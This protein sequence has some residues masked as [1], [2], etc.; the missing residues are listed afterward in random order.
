[1]TQKKTTLG[2]G[3]ANPAKRYVIAAVA[4]SLPYGAV[5]ADLPVP[6]P[7]SDVTVTDP[8]TQYFL[9]WFNRTDAAQASQPFHAVRFYLGMRFYLYSAKSMALAWYRPIL[10]SA[11]RQRNLLL[12][13]SHY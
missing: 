1:M 7:A 13:Y 2:L 11:K 5:A 8:V 3:I 6:Q 4:A 12:R 9:D 10:R